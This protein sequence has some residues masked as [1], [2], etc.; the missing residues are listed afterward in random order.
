MPCATEIEPVSPGICLWR[1]Y[2][3]SVKAELFSTALQTVAGTYLIDPIP[4]APDALATL[5]SLSTVIGIVVTNENHERAAA[6]FAEKFGAP[7]YADVAVA[8]PSQLPRIEPIRGET[9]PAGLT[10]IAIEGGPAGEISIH[11]DA[12][13]GTMVVGDALI[14]F[15]PYGFALLPAKYCSNFKTMRRS[16]SK[17]LDYPFERMLFAHGIPIL[18]RA[19]E[20]LDLLL[21][22]RR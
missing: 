12:K 1:F 2:D 15:E 4:V 8:G 10:A 22:E 5:T 3:S 18:S 7:V 19:R 14:N 17:L 21:K 9:S 11:W 13:G 6:Q 20:R 16:L